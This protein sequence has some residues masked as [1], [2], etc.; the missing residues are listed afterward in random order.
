METLTEKSKTTLEFKLSWKSENA[1]H[2]DCLWAEKV[3]IWRD[4]LPGQLGKKLLGSS[5][6]QSETV[7][8]D[9]GQFTQPYQAGK[10]I[11]IKPEQ[12]RTNF[13]GR[14]NIALMEGRFYPQRML[15][16]VPGVFP[17][18][19]GI[20][21]FLGQDNG[22][23]VFDL[24][25][26]LSR[27]TIHFTAQVHRIENLR[28]ERGGR[29]EDWLEAAAANGPGM[30]ARYGNKPTD[31]FSKE[32]FK[33]GNEDQDH[34]YYYQPRLVHHVDDT[35]EETITRLHGKM[36]RPE[37]EVLDLM[38]S[39]SSHLPEDLELKKMTV[40]G[41]NKEELLANRPATDILIHDLNRD[42]K[43]PF[44]DGSYDAI[45]CSL[46]VEYLADPQKVFR[47]LARILRINGT[48]AVSFS[49]RWFPGKAINLWNDLHDFERMGFVLELFSASG[50]FN[51]LQTFSRRGLPRPENDRHTELSFSDPVF[52]VSGKR[53]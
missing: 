50:T 25:H 42:P 34:F 20:S 6:G 32:G 15:S 31:F 1:V 33:R 44:A 28:V 27:K 35:A 38:G 45:L 11:R 49:N 12:F 26:P 47:E 8:V 19:I 2:T 5:E 39:W 10:V 4:C 23:L 53:S 13:I 43:L 21:R 29:C 36:L 18:S 52:M 24:N 9:P 51:N 41:M 17:N 37:M 22:R 14:R 30:Q 48:L 3:N 46:S 40:L 16:G 7:V